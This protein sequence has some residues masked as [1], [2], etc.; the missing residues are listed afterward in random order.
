MTDGLIIVLTSYV[1][2][3][4]ESNAECLFYDVMFNYILQLR[5]LEI[6]VHEMVNHSLRLQYQGSKNTQTV[7]VY[8]S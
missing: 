5:L 8:S 3:N 2:L 7:N 1:Y 4:G 6:A